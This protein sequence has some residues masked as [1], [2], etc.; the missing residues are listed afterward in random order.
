MDDLTMREWMIEAARQFASRWNLYAEAQAQEHNAPPV[1]A[2]VEQFC[3]NLQA[4]WRK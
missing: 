4:Q 2:E 1:S 3:A